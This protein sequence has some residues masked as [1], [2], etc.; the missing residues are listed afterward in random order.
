[1]KKKKIHFYSCNSRKHYF[2]WGSL[3]FIVRE[4]SQLNWKEKKEIV[5]NYLQMNAYSGMKVWKKTCN[6][7]KWPKME[8]KIHGITCLKWEI[9]VESV[10]ILRYL[11]SWKISQNLK[12][13][14]FDSLSLTISKENNKTKQQKSHERN[15]H[16]KA[17]I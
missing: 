12:A 5:C 15:V 10:E 7:E 3:F 13:F 2:I 8:R 6:K 9:N 14:Q 11:K 16:I 1:M 4:N 17:K